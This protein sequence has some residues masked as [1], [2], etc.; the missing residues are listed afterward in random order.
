MRNLRIL[1]VRATPFFLESEKSAPPSPWSPTYSVPRSADRACRDRTIAQIDGPHEVSIHVI[2]PDSVSQLVGPVWSHPHC[3]FL[4]SVQERGTHQLCGEP[5]E[6]SHCTH[7]FA[8]VRK[9]SPQ[10]PKPAVE[11]GIPVAAG[12]TSPNRQ[13]H[14]I[15]RR[16]IPRK[17]I[18]PRIH[19]EST[20]LRSR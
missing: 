2:V 7:S 6:R 1:P 5:F 18:P 4:E 8:G 9:C 19:R 10:N 3:S 15:D 17:I 16:M 11:M 14:F 20:P 12:M 13:P